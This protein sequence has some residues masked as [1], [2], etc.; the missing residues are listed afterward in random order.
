MAQEADLIRLVRAR[1]VDEVGVHAQHLAE[2]VV[3]GANEFGGTS[4]WYP[5]LWTTAV[6]WLIESGTPE[7]RAAPQAATDF[8]AAAPGRRE[9]A[10]E[11][12]L[13]RLRATIALADRSAP[14]DLE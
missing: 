12:E 4:E 7:A 14:A 13:P 10:V 3:S 6:D 11:A 8:G 9:P 5:F 1:L 2:A